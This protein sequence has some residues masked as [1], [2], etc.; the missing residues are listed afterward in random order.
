VG[1]VLTVAAAG[2][3]PPGTSL[4]GTVTL[5]G[6]PVEGA[7]L[8]FYPEAGD[9]QTSHA[10]T[11]KAGK[12]LAKVSPVPLVVTISKSAATGRKV[13]AFPD[14]PPADEM[15]ESLPSRYSDRKKT[16]LRVTPV[17]GK[18]TVSGFVLTSG[19]K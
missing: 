18:I 3:A 9:G 11:D 15:G 13:Q 17:E 8:Q 7:T 4:T 2:C 12:F 19:E 5:D 10:F 6:K 14:L 1:A 16:E